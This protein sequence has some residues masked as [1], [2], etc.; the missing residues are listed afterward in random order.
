MTRPASAASRGVK[1][2]ALE[3]REMHYDARSVTAAENRVE[4]SV[5]FL[6]AVRL[7]MVQLERLRGG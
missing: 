2:S 6:S 3:D 1:I 5:R 4:I 7:D